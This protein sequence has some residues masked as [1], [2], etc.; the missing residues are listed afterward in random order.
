[1]LAGELK[2]AAYADLGGLGAR[3][4]PQIP[5][6][7][8]MPN[9]LPVVLPWLVVLALLALPSNR[10]MRAW[11]IWAP[12][13]VVA[14]IG[15]VLQLPTAMTNDEGFHYVVQAVCSAAFGLAVAWLLGAVLARRGRILAIALMTL[16]FAAIS[17]LAFAMGPAGEQLSDL[18]RW[19]PAVLLYLVLFWVVDGLVFVGALNLTGWRCRSRFTHVRVALWLAVWL[20]AMWLVAGSVLGCVQTLTS[21]GGFEWLSLVVA[22]IIFTLVSIAVVAPY[23]ILSFTN[24]LYRERLK[25]LLRLP[26]EAP[27]TAA[28][29]APPVLEQA[30]RP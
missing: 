13:G 8:R 27:I 30:V 28:P 14:L 9:L 12:L 1:M 24:S 16:A 23:L 29:D 4:G 6:S 5:F 18:S 19:E 20:W 7:W 11:W 17:L 26:L 3:Q 2:V 15:A 25:Y 10:S 22:P 21:G